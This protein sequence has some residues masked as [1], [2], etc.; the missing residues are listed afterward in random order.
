VHVLTQDRHGR[1]GLAERRE[2]ANPEAMKLAVVGLLLVSGVAAAG[3]TAR[4]G[5][6]YGLSDDGAPG[7]V[8]VGPL[9]ALGERVGPFVGEVD[10][11]Y[12]SFFDPA[13]SPGGVHRF[14]LNLRADVWTSLR[15][16]RCAR[17][18]CTQAR[19]FYAE[20]GGAE[21]FGRWQV[22]AT[23]VA[24]VSSPQPEAHL[25]VG[26]EFDNQL[27]PHHN[28]W[29]VGLRFALSPALSSSIEATCLAVTTGGCQSSTASTSSQGVDKALF[30]EWMFLIGT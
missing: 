7:A 16:G 2:L 6:T 5:L 19:S 28:G 18:W 29:Q 17:A 8:E 24:P 27:Y 10:W 15:R 11:T 3:P 12:L 4:F 1:I 22:D 21:R 26:F 13:A 25:G 30:L 14:G 9:V 23:T 20:I